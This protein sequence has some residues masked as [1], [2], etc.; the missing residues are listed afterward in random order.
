MP[1]LSLYSAGSNARGQLATGNVEDAHR[2]TPCLFSGVAPG[3]L[4]PDVVAIEQIACGANHTLALLRRSSG[5]TELW[6]CGDGSR[7]QLGPSYLSDVEKADEEA[8][9]AT[10]VFRPLDLGLRTIKDPEGASLEL[11]TAR[12]IAAGW[13]T[14]YIVLSCSGRNDVLLVMGADDFGNLGIGGSRAQK[15]TTPVHVIRFDNL[16]SLGPTDAVLTIL[17][18]FTG[19]HHTM[20]KVR[21]TRSDGSIETVCVGWGTSRHGQ[22]GHITNASGRPLPFVSSPHLVLIPS[23]EEVTQLALGNQHTVALH[24]SGTL[25]ALGSNRKGQIDGL[26][27]LRDVERIGCTWN[28]TYAL[29][30]T[31]QVVATGSNTHSQLGRGADYHERNGTLGPVRFPFELRPGQIVHM[32]CGSEHVLC[33]VDRD[34][35]QR[36]VWGWGWNEHGNLG[37]GGTEDVSAPVKI[38]PSNGH[39]DATGRVLRVWAGCGTSWILVV[40]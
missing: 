10:A 25:C 27:T 34:D 28:G 33:I 22:L 32:V 24:S 8:A 3:V 38:W 16:M 15:T 11:Y 39:G 12:L 19:L 9:D 40:R 31:G 21:L 14:C 29:L 37:T 35:A 23:P 1:A 13:E 36:E 2:F 5:A 4:P 30:H 7:G 6:G 18:L 20:A 17:T 26:D